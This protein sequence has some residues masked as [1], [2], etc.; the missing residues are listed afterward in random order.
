MAET[1]VDKLVVAVGFKVDEQQFAN[2]K[3][4]FEK[5]T[6]A[7]AGVATGVYGVMAAAAGFTLV[8]AKQNADLEDAAKAL[9]LTTEAYTELT[10][11]AE[12]SGLNAE[13]LRMGLMT[14]QRQIGAAAGGSKE[15]KA[16]FDALGVSFLDAEGR[17]RTSAELLPELADGLRGLA[18][19]GERA[20]VQMRLLG[21]SGGRFNDFF[22]GGSERIAE[23]TGEAREFG[24]VLGS[25]VAAASASLDDNV[26]RLRTALGGLGRVFANELIPSIEP[27]VEQLT[28]FLGASD[29]IVRVGVDRAARVI[30]YAFDFLATD[31]GKAAAAIGA[32]AVGLSAA[33]AAN[34]VVGLLGAAGPAGAA[35]AGLATSFSSVAIPAGIVALAVGGVALVLEDLYVTGQ[36]GD[37]ITRR[38]A[39]SLG[40]GAETARLAGAAFRIFTNSIETTALV[41]E[42][43]LLEINAIIDA[44][45]V[46][47]PRAVEFAANALNRLGD[48]LGVDLRGLT[49][50]LSD[51]ALQYRQATIGGAAGLLESVATNQESTIGALRGERRFDRGEGITAD[52]F[53]LS[54]AIRSAEAVSNRNYSVNV[55]ANI[56]RDASNEAIISRV[57]KETRKALEAVEERQ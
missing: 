33:R 53:G 52:I 7:A 19:D 39:D 24:A 46:G 17:V 11:A 35:L 23:L 4:A 20:S 21:E 8:I 51:F 22:S 27:V 50:G 48:L 9:N 12:L 10:Y 54:P 45:G 1:V 41:M 55:S 28:A 14:L 57:A 44:I 38:L 18:S 42:G 13:Q 16:T 37:S 26:F 36:G 5:V 43:A 6:D 25:D 30:G 2:A 34:G 29:G 40:V 31:A 15:A 32:V 49:S 47:I 3:A 56:A